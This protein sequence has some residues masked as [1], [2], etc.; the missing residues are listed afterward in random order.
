MELTQ[1]S[2]KLGKELTKEEIDTCMKIID[3]SG[4]GTVNF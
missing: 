4:D 2:K 3:T 1:V